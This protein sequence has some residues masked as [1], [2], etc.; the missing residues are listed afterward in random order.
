LLALG[1]GEG[2]GN[3]V[4]VPAVVMRPILFPSSSVNQRLPSEPTV[5]PL[6]KL[7]PVGIGNSVNATLGAGFGVGDALGAGEGL[8]EALGDG[9]VLAVG[10]GDALAVGVGDALS[11]EPETI[12][13]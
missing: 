12:S 5:I 11:A 1:V 4:I 3:S 6:G 8:A 7:V 10:D 9:D 2:S 13:R